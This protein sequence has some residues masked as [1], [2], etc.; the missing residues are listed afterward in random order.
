[1]QH[2]ST[3]IQA[4]RTALGVPA[5]ASAAQVTHA[6]RRLARETHPDVSTHGDAATRFDTVRNA[7]RLALDAARRAEPD[8]AP[9]PPAAPPR[10]E[11]SAPVARVAASR[12]PGV[13]ILVG[14]ALV[15]P[16]PPRSDRA[17]R[18]TTPGPS[19]A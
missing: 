12:L 9:A 5:D 17:R 2:D 15:Q 1:M 10:R 7:Y 6:Y 4:A 16:L 14:P 8:C 11:W 3:S 19:D 18:S 13:S